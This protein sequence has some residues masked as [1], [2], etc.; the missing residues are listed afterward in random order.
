MTETWLTGNDDFSTLNLEGYQPIESKVRTTGQQRG[1]VCLYV[2]ER[3]T[4]EPIEF[5]T[6]GEC[7]ILNVCLDSQIF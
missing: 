7:A 1:F 3:F 4:Y 2:K 5:K 6:E